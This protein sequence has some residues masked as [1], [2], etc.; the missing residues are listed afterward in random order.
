[1]A[2]VR[3]ATALPAVRA[4]VATVP[5][6]QAVRP[7]ARVRVAIAPAAPVARVAAV[8]VAVAA[9]RVAADSARNIPQA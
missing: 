1:M 4:R 7:A 6:A 9:A 5:A 2:H 3:P 8:P